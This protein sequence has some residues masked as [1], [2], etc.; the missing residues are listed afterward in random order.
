VPALAFCANVA[1]LVDVR[2]ALGIC[3]ICWGDGAPGPAI[4]VVI[5]RGDAEPLVLARGR[6]GG[7]GRTIGVAAGVDTV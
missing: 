5:R 3:P 4:A 1:E 6:F 2:W 7:G